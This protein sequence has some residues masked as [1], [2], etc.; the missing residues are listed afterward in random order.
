MQER[1]NRGRKLK[2]AI[3]KVRTT[4]F[5]ANPIYIISFMKILFIEFIKVH[6]P[7]S[8]GFEIEVLYSINNF[9]LMIHTFL[10]SS[11]SAN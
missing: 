1:G 7:N 6:H 9:A 3:K 4:D 11:Q 5:V 8:F 2:R 10:S